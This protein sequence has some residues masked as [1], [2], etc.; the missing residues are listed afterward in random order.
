MHDNS[1]H[2]LRMKKKHSLIRLKHKIEQRL[3]D[4]CDFPLR[5][6]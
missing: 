2:G 3:I 5:D 6:L 1:S 4:G